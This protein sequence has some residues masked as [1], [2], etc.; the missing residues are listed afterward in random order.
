MPGGPIKTTQV[1]SIPWSLPLFIS[2][3]SCV[4]RCKSSPR[5]LA[6]G[7]KL[8]ELIDIIIDEKAK[9]FVVAVGVAPTWAI[10][11]LHAAGIIVT[12][13]PRCEHR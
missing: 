8:A 10:D 2:L 11:K 9:L 12:L 13:P 4:I 3:I 7:G 6:K 5:F 1:T